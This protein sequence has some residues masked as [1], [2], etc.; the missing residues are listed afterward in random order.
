MGFCYKV[1]YLQQHFFNFQQIA[2]IGDPEK[3]LE[4]MVQ[5]QKLVNG[6]VKT[7]EEL[8]ILNLEAQVWTI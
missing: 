2:A 7:Y 1:Q 8:V 6:E 5:L 4:L 3:Q